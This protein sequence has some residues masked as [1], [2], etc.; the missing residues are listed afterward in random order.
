[1]EET[2]DQVVQ[3]PGVQTSFHIQRARA[4]DRDSLSWM[5]RR[6]SP[7]LI[8]QARY[9]LGRDLLSFY[10]PEDLVAEVWAV[11]LARLESMG[12]GPEHRTPALLR[13]LGTT[14]V[15]QANHLARKHI[16]K[17]AV[18]RGSDLVGSATDT[19]LLSQLP[20]ETSGVLTRAVREE[21]KGVL[22]ACIDALDPQDRE[23]VILRGIEQHEN[24]EVAEL[25]DMKP[26]S[27]SHRYR[28]ALDKL[29]EKLPGSVFDELEKD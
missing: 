21:R 8:A 15:Y 4:G 11:V 13:F 9:R 12:P 14:L 2:G 1:M 18:A 10:E 27:V 3:D 20:A 7:L 29:L 17:E 25:L 24:Q 6:F 5:V 19:D 16:H 23:I 26:D 28:R 22:L